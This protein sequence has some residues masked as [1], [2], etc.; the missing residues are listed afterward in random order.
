M[1]F[2]TGMFSRMASS[3]VRAV[4]QRTQAKV[5]RKTVGRAQAKMMQGMSA[6]DQ[7]AN[8]AMDGKGLK[9]KGKDKEEKG[10]KK[11]KAG[12]VKAPKVKG[13]K[14]KGKAKGGGGGAEM[15]EDDF[16]DEEFDEAPASSARSS[17]GVPRPVSAREPEADYYESEKTVSID[18]N[19]LNAQSKPELVGWLVAMTGTHKGEDFRIFDGKNILGTGADCE[20]VVTDPYLS[21]KHCTIR[22]EG[23]NSTLIDLDSTNGTFVNQK[24]AT[25]SELIDNDTIRIGRTE[26]KFKSLM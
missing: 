6:A 25:K 12:K 22:H 9:G 5:R 8:K 3:R 17:N 2:I 7:K 14:A 26:F 13:P 18:L 21:A 10:G 4:K 1:N 23:G 20:L 11:K 15:E 19:E 24:R 16:F